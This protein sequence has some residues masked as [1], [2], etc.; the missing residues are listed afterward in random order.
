[1]RRAATRRALRRGSSSDSR[2]LRRRRDE[3]RPRWSSWKRERLVAALLEGLPLRVDR[4]RGV[5][6]LALFLRDARVL[7]QRDGDRALVRLRRLGA[8]AAFLER[9]SDDGEAGQGAARGIEPLVEL[10]EPALVDVLEQLLAEQV[11]RTDDD[12]VLAHR[13]EDLLQALPRLSV[14]VADM[15]QALGVVE[16]HLAVVPLELLAVLALGLLAQRPLLFLQDGHLVIDVR[17]VVV[18]G[19]RAVAAEELV[20]DLAQR[21]E[22]AVAQR[23]ER[24]RVEEREQ[25]FRLELQV[26]AVHAVLLG[27]RDD[28]PL[29]LAEQHVEALVAPVESAEQDPA[30]LVGP[31]RTA[32]PTSSRRRPART[33]WSPRPPTRLRPTSSAARSPR[34]RRTPS[35]RRRPCAASRS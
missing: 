16:V 7:A 21:L 27:E 13:R 20:A 30:H 4:L 9:I 35:A 34:A 29:V 14:E 28:A 10:L 24:V 6:R 32:D 2:T 19:V 15:A 8:E 11:R 22:L 23:E 25:L 18:E 31:H 1:M 5:R 12:S 26:L 17:R 3:I 33:S